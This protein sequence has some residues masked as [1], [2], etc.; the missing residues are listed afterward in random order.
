MAFIHLTKCFNISAKIARSIIRNPLRGKFTM[1]RLWSE[2]SYLKNRTNSHNVIRMGITHICTNVLPLKGVFPPANPCDV[3]YKLSPSTY[4]NEW[5]RNKK[6]SKYW[7][8]LERDEAKC[9][10]SK[11]T[12]A[13]SGIRTGIV[14]VEGE[15]TDH[16]TTTTAQGIFYLNSQSWNV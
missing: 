8:H 5:F 1:P 13:F 16:L 11:K 9:K 4:S 15:H 10:W 2:A 6:D 12:V 3:I 14:K 7:K